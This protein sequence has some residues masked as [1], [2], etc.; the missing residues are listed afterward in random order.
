[1]RPAGSA[2]SY[3]SASSGPPNCADPTKV[4]RLRQYAA[5]MV[6]KFP[7]TLPGYEA[8]GDHDCR[9][10]LETPITDAAGIAART[11]SIFNTGLPLP[12]GAHTGVLPKAA[13]YRPLPQTNRRHR[14]LPAR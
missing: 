13:G 3:R 4:D 7:D 9:V 5:R 11:D 6:A 8:F 1:M 10:V 14:P 12:V 2:Y